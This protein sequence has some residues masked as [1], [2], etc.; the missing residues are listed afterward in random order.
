[1]NLL[2]ILVN[3]TSL[4]CLQTQAPI[5]NYVIQYGRFGDVGEVHTSTTKALH[6]RSSSFSKSM[7]LGL[8]DQGVVYFFRVAAQNANGVGPF[9]R[10]RLIKTGQPNGGKHQ[11]VC[12]MTIKKNN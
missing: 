2:R 3:W 5:I 8:L 10:D 12:S 7:G 1:M 4:P 6:I 11:L 9:S